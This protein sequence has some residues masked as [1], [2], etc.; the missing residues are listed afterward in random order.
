MPAY[1]NKP[2]YCLRPLIN[3]MHSIVDGDLSQGEKIQKFSLKTL[4]IWGVPI[5][6]VKI[7]L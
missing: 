2:L 7:N 4:H 1:K 3:A 5:N 6:Q